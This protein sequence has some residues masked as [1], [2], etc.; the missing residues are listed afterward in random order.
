MIRLNKVQQV[1]FIMIVWAIGLIAIDKK[2]NTHPER[3]SA[4]PTAGKPQITMTFE[5][6][7]CESCYDGMF[8]SV[9][10]YPWLSK[11]KVIQK[12]EAGLPTESSASNTEVK[13]PSVEQA[14]DRANSGQS[15]SD[16]GYEGSAMADLNTEQLSL[17]DFV[18]LDHTVRD[19]GMVM[20]GLKLSGIPHF[21]LV[22]SGLHICCNMCVDA[23]KAVYT[24]EGKPTPFMEQLHLL[25]APAVNR[26]DRTVRA[27][28]YNEADV[29][30]FKRSIE[31]MGLA[32]R[33]IKIEIVP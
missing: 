13:L 17:I 28:F 3:T 18:A 9:K 15:Q 2:L 8:A 23:T 14:N 20:K 24:K 27:E 19:E 33:S 32:A 29:M 16:T 12:S 26:I 6:F 10:H 22:A 7:C 4:P 5:H 1:I 30:L 31:Q 21:V 11:P 25:K